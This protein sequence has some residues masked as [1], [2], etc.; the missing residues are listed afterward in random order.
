MADM[1]NTLLFEY[2]N[3]LSATK[4]YKEYNAVIKEGQESLKIM[5]SELCAQIREEAEQN[6]I[7]NLEDHQRLDTRISGIG[8]KQAEIT[9]KIELCFSQ[10]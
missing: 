2:E 3:R 8:A 5:A 1:L 10:C 4:V 9:P 7:K 6:V